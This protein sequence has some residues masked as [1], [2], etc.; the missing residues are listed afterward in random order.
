M[1]PSERSWLAAPGIWASSSPRISGLFLIGMI[2]VAVVCATQLRFDPDIFR[3]FSSANS[4]LA[5]Y[6]NF[7]E[8]AGPKP[9]HIV[10][11]VEADEPMSLDALEHIRDISLD[12]SL[13][14][15]VGAV[16][17][18]GTVRFPADASA[19]AG[20]PLLPINM[21]ADPIAERLRAFEMSKPLSSTLLAADRKAAVIHIAVDDNAPPDAP[22]AIAGAILTVL[23]DAGDT[24]LRFAIAGEDLIGPEI[25]RALKN[26]L[27][28]YTVA[29]GIIALAF[30]AW[31]F[32]DARLILV[33][34]VPAGISALFSLAV[35]VA[36]GIPVT[37]V[38]NVVPI[39][40]FILALADCVHLTIAYA[41]DRQTRN[42]DAALTSV[43]RRVG[44]A[45]AL[46][47]LTTAMA[48]AAIFIVGDLQ[49]RELSLVGGVGVCAGYLAIIVTF[50]VLVR[51]LCP[52]GQSSGS[53]PSVAIEGLAIRAIS[54]PRRTAVAGFIITV[55]GLIMCWHAEPW[56][57]LKQNLPLDGSARIAEQ[58]VADKFG[59]FYRLWVE[60]SRD[61]QAS[62]QYNSAQRMAA[63]SEAAPGYPVI[64]H[65][66][67]MAWSGG[68]AH[69]MLPFLPLLEQQDG[70]ER[71]VVLMPEPMESRETL[72]VYDQ[73]ERTASDLGASL[74]TGLPTILRNEATVL[75]HQIALSLAIACVIACLLVALAFHRFWLAAV[76]VMPNILPL[77]LAAGL[78]VGINDW[79]IGPSA[80]LALTVAFGIAIDDSIHFVSRYF[81]A[82]GREATLETALRQAA[83]RA[84]WPMTI[85]TVL[86]C[87]GLS[88]PLFSSFETV[89][90]FAGIQ[91]AALIVALVSDLVLLP[92][93]I[94]L[95][96][97]K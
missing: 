27:V 2:L 83:S 17:S 87:A 94:Y 8:R 18:V 39:L 28:L 14:D 86:I 58:Q 24:G 59:G 43:I 66:L 91:V 67:V 33:C 53:S 36:L 52:Q 97:D 96:E 89:R 9:R 74:I 30:A 81:E 55:T 48:F 79:R 50:P 44:P 49:I 63:L 57:T 62:A 70:A 25:V 22:S 5:A 7:L 34:I 31:L 72:Q 19:Y 80:V 68:E 41:Q 71:M 40:I 51:V 69:D 11:L 60:F 1:H 42:E 38:N 21:R 47:S 46:T 84:G 92:A 13:L 35:F 93:L 64:S 85:T 4:N 26:D 95:R 78:Y 15:G 65:S 29:G 12:I 88:V 3:S 10:V 37:V 61:E 76:L 75:V 6:T 54:S 23:D 45:C 77:V 16:V 20:Q 73:V 90:A 32:R 56:F 82:R